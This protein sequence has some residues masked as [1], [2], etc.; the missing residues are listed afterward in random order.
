LS[1]R[2]ATAQGK[3]KDK[4]LLYANIVFINDA[5]SIFLKYFFAY[6]FS[7]GWMDK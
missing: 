1:G 2:F 5:D 4:R 3:R 6:K 7:F